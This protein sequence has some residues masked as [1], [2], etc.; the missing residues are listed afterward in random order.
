[1]GFLVDTFNVLHYRPT[2]ALCKLMDIKDSIA[3]INQRLDALAWRQ[4][5]VLTRLQ[6]MVSDEWW[7]PNDCI[8]PVPHGRPDPE[9]ANKIE[10][11]LDLIE[12]WEADHE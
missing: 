3:P 8:L 5:R 10:Q 7:W 2:L 12:A 4:L 1:M 11:V 9:A 6:A